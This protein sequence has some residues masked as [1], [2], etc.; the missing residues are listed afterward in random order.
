MPVRFDGTMERAWSV[1]GRDML[2][3]SVCTFK[4]VMVGG[5]GAE[6]LACWPKACA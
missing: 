5:V 6:Q 2:G 3:G 4:C 1:C